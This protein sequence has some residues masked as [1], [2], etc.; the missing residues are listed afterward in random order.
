M[1]CTKWFL[2]REK[3]RTVKTLNTYLIVVKNSL[4][5]IIPN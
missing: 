5:S 1:K 2:L 4:F 3:N